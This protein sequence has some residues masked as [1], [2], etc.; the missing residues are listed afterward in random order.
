MDA[1]FPSVAKRFNRLRLL[2]QI[3]IGTV[4]HIALAGKRLKSRPEFD[5]IGR[6]EIDHLDLA[7]H[8]LLLQQRVHHQQA[9]ARHQPVS[10]AEG[11][12]IEIQRL[13][14]RHRLERRI[15]QAG[16]RRRRW[17]RNRL[18]DRR[19]HSRWIDA[20]MAVER[21]S[22]DGETRPLGFARP[23]EVG[24]PQRLQFRQRGVHHRRITTGQRIIDQRFNARPPDIELQR[25][26]KMRI[27]F[28]HRLWLLRIIFRPH[29]PDLRNVHPLIGVALAGDFGPDTG[30]PGHGLAP[31]ARRRFYQRCKAEF[32]TPA[33]SSSSFISLFKTSPPVARR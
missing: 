11:V 31:A 23:G 21:D 22:I 33:E 29:Q 2:R 3:G 26:I 15:E 20:F 17:L 10:P 13:G 18:L 19:E 28:P 7:R 30:R 9:V 6:I 24:L 5:A 32:F 4:F 8:A 25:R 14:E 1:E 12:A 27:I 16:L